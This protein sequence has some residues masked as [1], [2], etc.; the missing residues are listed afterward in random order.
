[1]K[2]GVIACKIME[3]EIKSLIKDDHEVKKIEFLDFG[4][5]VN[6]DDLLSAVIDKINSMKNSVDCIFLGYGYCQVLEGIEDKVDIPVFMP[7]A[8]DCIGV[9]LTPKGY[10][11][12]KSKEAGTWFMTH[13]WCERGYEDTVIKEL[14]L[15]T[16]KDTHPGIEPM[17]IAKMLFK[18]YTKVL[19]IDTS[20]GT[21]DIDHLRSKE[22]ADA[23]DLKVD[24]IEGTTDYLKNAYERMKNHECKK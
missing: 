16:V 2:I 13:G 11:E 12:Q 22:F 3:E 17:D 1:M 18:N 9:F 21:Q 23:F 10:A 24:S 6:S 14:R 5:H 8:P 4:L 7:D 15:D 19:Y 20:T